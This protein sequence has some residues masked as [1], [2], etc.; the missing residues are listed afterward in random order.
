MKNVLKLIF[1]LSLVALLGIGL[2]RGWKGLPPFG[3]LLDPFSGVWQVPLSRVLKDEAW[4]GLV[5]QP[6]QVVWDQAR[7]PHIQA[8]SHLDAIRVQG[9]IHASQRFFQMDVQARVG[10][11]RLAELIG[12]RGRELD[13][14]FILTGLKEASRRAYAKIVQDPES[15]ELLQAYSQGVNHWLTNVGRAQVPTEYRFLGI[16]PSSWRPEYTA[17]I[18]VTMAFRL[19]GRTYD[20]VMTQYKKQFGRH[21]VEALFPDFFPEHLEAP[22]LKR[23]VPSGLPPLPIV[24]SPDFETIFTEPPDLVQPFR[25]NGSNNW[26]V[27]SA[28]STTGHS[29]LA[30]DT[31][32]GL[33][34]PSFWFE[35]QIQSDQVNVY[36][37]A[38]AGSPGV[39][40][41]FN[42][43]V[44][45]G[46]TNGTT[47]V[48]DW[49]EIRFKNQQ[50]L[51]Y[52]GPQGE[53][54]AQVKEERLNVRGESPEVVS[55]LW[56]SFGPVVQRK[57]DRGLVLRW[58][59]HDGADIVSVFS[60][61]NRARTF[62]ECQK[63]VQGYVVP[64]QN[65]ICADKDNIG[66]VHAGAIPVRARG[67]GRYVM[68][69]SQMANH[70]QGYYAPKHWPHVENPPEHFVESANQR[71]LPSTSPLYLGW[72]FEEV[73]R[74]QRM[75]EWLRSKDKF[76]PA[77]LMQMQSDVLE[78]LARHVLPLLLDQLKNLSPEEMAL[79]GRMRYWNYRAESESA[80]ITFF[81]D[82]WT[83]FRRQLWQDQL[84]DRKKGIWP[85]HQRTQLL[86][87]N[88]NRN[89]THPDREWVDN[90]STA[91]VET[92]SDLVT[93]AFK[94]ARAGLIQKHGPEFEKWAYGRTRPATFTH[95]LRIP[96]FGAT[97]PAKGSKFALNS[98][99]VEHGPGWRMVVALGERPEAWT[100]VA[101]STEGDPLGRDYRQGIEPWGQAQYK[102][103]LFLEGEARREGQKLWRFEP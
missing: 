34:L 57:R 93:Q 73:Y 71:P 95:M 89:S 51:E 42:P 15:Q 46:V 64:I 44:A 39:L 103:V 41:G 38:F 47:D 2:G 66:L 69:G 55:S 77:D 83:E 22:F 16:E 82:W 59:V 31:H 10:G 23:F 18:F 20:L 78:P 79:V 50:S 35:G 26:A 4:R 54:I 36:G 33:I 45:W 75:E 63:A 30:N 60:R 98:V 84:G 74:G 7:V 101:G 40:V 86:L 70:W 37:G 87:E 58:S 28:L 17:E 80:E 67:L 99:Q 88:L 65:F 85:K 49:Y 29:I 68:D 91:A 52:L 92:L 14:F 32:L 53:E 9:F 27:G 56:T 6:V 94:A 90:K 21:K 97:T 3:P 25:S 76:S 61:L 62:Q 48:T 24:P 19:S 72:D 43:T 96:G 12:R 11:A 100:S 8:K 1:V 102:Q 13:E 5:Q 81:W